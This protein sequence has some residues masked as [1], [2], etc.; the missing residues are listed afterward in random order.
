MTKSLTNLLETLRSEQPL[1]VDQLARL[2]DMPPASADYFVEIWP[3]LDLDRRRELMQHFAE[4]CQSN[5]AVDF[6]PFALLGIKDDDPR[7][8]LAALDTLWDAEDP[9]LIKRILRLAQG[10]PDLAVQAAA[11]LLLGRFVLQGELG[12][13]SSRISQS[14]T[15]DL[16]QIYHNSEIALL[17]RCRALEALAFSSHPEIL[18]LIAGA[19]RS[20]DE[21]LKISAVSAMG[22]T[23]DPRWEPII[24]AELGSVNPSMRYHAARAAGRL[25][26]QNLTPQLIESLDDPDSAVL[27]ASVWALGEI[28]G[29]IARQALEPLLD[30]EELGEHVEAALDVIELSA[31]MISTPLLSS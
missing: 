23:A 13:L 10:D 1:P 12:D 21:T 25:E 2:S 31:G 26:L 20:G 6:T 8:R 4:I 28:G 11:A 15:D 27:T 5:F 29:T 16:L 24:A 30:D 22:H 17:V 7:V 18:D 14:L 19:Y 3:T 9:N